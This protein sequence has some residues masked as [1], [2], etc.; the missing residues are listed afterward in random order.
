VEV[1]RAE[2][3]YARPRTLFAATFLGSGTVLM[4]RVRGG[5]ARFS[6]LDFGVR[7]QVPHEDG[8]HAHLL[9]R[10]EDVT[11]S[12]TQPEPGSPSLGTGAVVDQTFAGAVRR[13]RIRLETRTEAHPASS[14]SPSR[15]GVLV[16][17]ALQ[18]QQ[19][20][21]ERELWVSIQRWHFLDPP[22]A[23]LLVADDGRGSARRLE[24]AKDLASALDARVT[25]LGV[26][27]DAR[28]SE[29][30]GWKLK[31]RQAAA[32][33]EDAEL[34]L[35][36]GNAAAQILHEQA[37][38]LSQMIVLPMET[39]PWAWLDRIGG[40]PRVP[41]GRTITPRPGGAR[42]AVAGGAPPPPPPRNRPAVERGPS[43][44]RDP[45]RC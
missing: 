26:A 37:D 16:E 44:T 20:L 18:A 35:R 2:D 27:E 12:G 41:V 5:E 23:S 22:P 19:P 45:L 10:P 21:P 9:I 4:G 7:P 24:L 25:L 40:Q 32:G 11:V 33:L 3:L 1:G 6:G 15:E 36:F 29:R 42:G 17:A 28:H 38:L 31:R 14:P 13:V 8:A 43:Q 39:R 30:L 34:R